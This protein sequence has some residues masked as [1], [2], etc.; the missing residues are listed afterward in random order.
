MTRGAISPRLAAY[1]ALA[2]VSMMAGVLSGRGGM[3]ALGA[4]F[5]V[6]VLAAA[7]LRPDDVTAS[8]SLDRTSVD[9]GQDV[10]VS[11][12]ADGRPGQVVEVALV[13]PVGT[14][15]PDGHTRR[16]RLDRTGHRRESFRIRT[17]SRGTSRLG[18]GVIR[19]ADPLALV[20]TDVLIGAPEVLRVRPVVEPVRTAAEPKRLQVASGTHPARSAGI[21]AE[22][23]GLRTYQPGDR[24]RDV[25]WRASARRDSLMVAQRHPE[26]GADVIVFVDTFE[27]DGL[28]QTIRAG[29]AVTR[30]QLAQ[31][32][33]VGVIAF[34]GSM[35]TVPPGSGRRQY[36]LIAEALVDVRPVFSWADKEICG[37]APR[38][39]PPASTIL[40]VSPLVDDRALGAIVDL[41]RRR[42]EIAV[43]EVSPEGWVPPVDRSD[44]SAVVAR[45]L[46]S[47][48]RGM[49]RAR[50][51]EA[52]VPVV[53]WR[54]G[55]ALE[56]ALR[57]L[58]A[59]RRGRGRWLAS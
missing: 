38:S 58:A 32:D 11:V 8:A 50:L 23:A 35:R 51:A 12:D 42:H 25:S 45:R 54:D 24:A 9:A 49:R 6:A 2:V 19:V 47:M 28:E 44:P 15:A 1:L 21:G 52:G 10:T 41:R 43:I 37:I 18:L 48:Q 3:I 46:W 39:L 27:A 55:D 5:G 14:D 56:L 36:E 33:R 29:L 4:P 30:L 31:R 7:A 59:L 17:R 53:A 34:G 22:F 13:V 57:R 20:A 16:F 40:A 26:R